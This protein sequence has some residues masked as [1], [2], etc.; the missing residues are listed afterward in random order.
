MPN[1][2]QN[3]KLFIYIIAACIICAG[4]WY[5]FSSRD[6]DTDHNVK[7]T[8]QRAS[9]YN[10]Q[11]GESIDQAA[12]H[13]GSASSELDRADEANRRAAFILSEDKERANEC[14]GIIVK[15]QKNNH[16]A[17]QLLADIEQANQEKSIQK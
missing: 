6:A 4:A 16:R 8:V 3:S 2:K 14:T 1:E 10:R 13:V 12:E 9:D 7:G 11:A 17:K 15:L 5:L